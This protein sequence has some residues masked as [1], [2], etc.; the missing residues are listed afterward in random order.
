MTAP[1]SELLADF[2]GVVSGMATHAPDEYPEWSYSTY[3]NQVV[4]VQELWS[5]IRPQLKRDLEEAEF[6][7]QK[8][9]EALQAFRV[10]HKTNGRKAM[11]AIYN[12]GVKGLR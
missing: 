3:E 9:H 1:L 6:I 8:L 2:A 10:E 5:V 11:W 7:E 12:L 4:D